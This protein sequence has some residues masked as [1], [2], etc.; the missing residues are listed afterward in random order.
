M[1]K[2]RKKIHPNGFQKIVYAVARPIVKH[3]VKKKYGFSIPK[4]DVLDIKEP[5]ICV[6][7]HTTDNDM[8]YTML[9]IKNHMYFVCSE[10]LWRA[11]LLSRLMVFGGNPIPMFKGS[12]AVSTTQEIMR[13]VRDGNNIC[14]FPEG[15]RTFNG[16]T[17]PIAASTGKLIKAANCG[18]VT[19]HLQGGYFVAPRWTKKT[20]RGPIWGSVVRYYTK[21]EIKKMS[22]D[23]VNEILRTDLYEDAYETM[24]KNP[25]PYKGEDLAEGIE[26]FLF[27][28][29]NC[30]GFETI[31][32]HGD[33]FHCTCCDMKGRI[34]EYGTLSGEKLPFTTIPQ[35]EDWENEEFDAIYARQGNNMHF[36]NEDVTL[37]ELHPDHT[38]EVRYVGT[39][40][41]D[42]DGMYIGDYKF[43]FLEL[44]GTEYINLGNT[45]LLTY[46]GIHY[47]LDA[48]YLNGVKY[49][50]LYFKRM[51]EEC[52]QNGR[53][54][55]FGK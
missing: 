54:F 7:N 43:N 17:N 24:A 4:E 6:S 21:D 3:N 48:K 19:F 16:K 52:Q 11:G 45:F 38:T 5:F 10:H 32:S 23:E 46:D 14:I 31:R 29:P 36:T 9:A 30:K 47:S 40:T 13:R 51:E 26:N 1:K 35:W 8:I 34:D 27:I 49:R 12:V 22:V 37:T 42:R 53:K 44:Q 20:R 15:S 25:I 50:K 55:D 33:E 39:L 28:C 18:L 41:A 2:K